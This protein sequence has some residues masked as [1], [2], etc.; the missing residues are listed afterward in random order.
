MIKNKF[1]LDYLVNCK[2]SLKLHLH[3]SHY[4]TQMIIIFFVFIPVFLVCNV[5]KKKNAEG[6]LTNVIKKSY[7]RMGFKY[8]INFSWSVAT[9]CLP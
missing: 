9:L 1:T 5:I 8:R 4:T 3:F 2:V 6:V 7:P